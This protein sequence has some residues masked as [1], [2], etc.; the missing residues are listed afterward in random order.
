MAKK[1]RKKSK[2]RAIQVKSVSDFLDIRDDM[3]QQVAAE[4]FLMGKNLEGSIDRAKVVML[5]EIED[6][7]RPVQQTDFVNFI[8]GIFRAEA[9][10]PRNRPILEMEVGRL[11]ELYKD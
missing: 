1:G 9:R 10:S 2:K 5:K 11:K 8:H 4:R 7:L 3:I 6:S